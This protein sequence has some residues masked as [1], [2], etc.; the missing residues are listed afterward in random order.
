VVT[1]AGAPSGW[2]NQSF[3]T[4]WLGAWTLI[5]G[6]NGLTNGVTSFQFQFWETESTVGGSDGF[7][8]EVFD[9]S[10]G[11][12]STQFFG[13]GSG[14]TVNLTGFGTIGKVII[15]DLGDGSHATGDGVRL[16]NLQSDTVVIPSGVPEPS[17]YLMV[18]SA[19][20]GLA[21]FRRRRP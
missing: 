13:Q 19:L 17:T 1:N 20:A 10:N 5:F 15:T 9:P 6:N 8:V 21:M 2:G 12:L 16:D 14:T 3:D 4:G 11:S 7:K 18:G